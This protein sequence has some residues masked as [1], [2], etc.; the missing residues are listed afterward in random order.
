[1]AEVFPKAPLIE[2]VFEIRF[3]ANLRIEENKT[4]FFSKVEGQFPNI[5][6]PNYLATTEPY[7]GTLPFKFSSVE[8][9]KAIQLSVHR[10]SFHSYIYRGFDIFSIE[11][12]K[13]TSLF[14]EVYNISKLQRTGLRYINHIPFLPEKECVPIQRFLNAK[15]LFPKSIGESFSLIQN[16]FVAKLGEGKLRMMIQNQTLEDGKPVLVLDFDY[17]FE[18]NLN[19]DRVKEY[20]NNSHRH[21]KQ[22]FLDL[23]TDEYKKIMRG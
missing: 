9:D 19:R 12:L 8:G 7:L 4:A 21:T 6:L 13:Y 17:T 5:F 20:L 15:Y 16:T 1:M 14:C 3:P 10:F 23:I 18:G 22:V 2:T 11:A